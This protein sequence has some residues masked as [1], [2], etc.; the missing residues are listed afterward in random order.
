MTVT[1]TSARVSYAGNGSTTTF[2]IPWYFLTAAD[3]RVI[4][5]S[6]LGAETVLALSTNYTVSGAG[7]PNGGSVTLA[8]APAS[9]ETVTII[10]DPVI[11]QATDYLPNDPFPAESHERALDLL[12]MAAQRLDD[13]LDRALVLADSDTPGSGAYQAGG[14]RITGLSPGTQPSDAVTLLQVQALITTSGGGG[15]GG[16]GGSNT[17]VVPDTE[18]E[19]I[20]N[21]TLADPD[22]ADMFTPL[23][24]QYG[25]LASQVLALNG[26]VGSI[27]T[28]VAQI[29]V[30]ITDMQ[31]DI[32]ALSVISGDA[33]NIITLIS[34]ET[35]N[36]IAG[37]TAIVGTLEKIGAADG[38]NV[39][40]LMN[41]DTVKISSTETIGQ[42]FDGI[43]TQFGTVTAS[44]AAEATARASADTATAQTIAKIGALN[45]AGTAFVIDLNTAYVGASESLGQRLSALA[46]AINNNTAAITSEQSVRASTDSSL[47]SSITTLQSTSASQATTISQQATTINGIQAKYAVKVDNNGYVSGFGLI[48][49]ANNGAVVSTFNVL[50]DNFKVFN[51]TTAVAPFS[52]SGGVVRAENLQVRNANIE[53]LQVGK[54]V[55][56]GD[57]EFTP[58]AWAR[59]YSNLSTNAA[60]FTR[61]AGFATVVR[62]AQGRYTFTFASAL[63]NRLYCVIANCSN[64]A[65]ID[66]GLICSAYDVTT[67]G[68]KLSCTNAN[69]DYR[70]TNLGQVIVYGNN[71]AETAPPPGY[72]YEDDPSPPVWGGVIP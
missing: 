45:Q 22:L 38:D 41:Q 72:D 56:G 70:D 48:S 43:A 37:D 26:T 55:A 36:R 21:I 3:L 11:Q 49:T 2:T 17:I 15:T 69:G 67:T 31:A 62:S 1:T 66:K 58:K 71:E 8:T 54:L 25:S 34:T 42:K 6:A 28:S 5:R 24:Q 32:D 50:A 30:T 23:N 29:N 53:N 64:E 10:R 9:G 16:G 47:A 51:G 20:V 35:T 60:Y 40:F 14:N 12:T 59:F 57:S 13:R 19:R 68:F 44:V 65:N 61:Q 27:N 63:P 4:R 33:N 52:V 18:V 46:T 7:N 39:S